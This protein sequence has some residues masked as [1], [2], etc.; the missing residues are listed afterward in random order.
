MA[1]SQ[2]QVVARNAVGKGVARKLRANNQIPAI[3][4]GK[5]VE[6]CPVTVEPKA[7]ETA[8]STKAGWNTLITLK[9]EGSFDGKVVILK[10]LQ[11]EPIKGSLLHADFETVNMDKQLHIMVPVHVS[12]TSMGE[13][14]GGTLQII[15]HEL[16]CYCLPND[17][18][19]AIVIDVTK[20][21]IGDVIH[22]DDISLPAAV[23]VPH[24]V[25]FTVVTVAGRKAEAEEAAEGEGEAEEATA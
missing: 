16:E 22:I 17:I 8:I 9:G 25:N 3:V 11:K 12:G 20:L 15:R 18:P 10:D 2:L 4:Y 1:Q 5:G 19:E 7:L 6:P 23:A 14:E 21:K 24:D 13:K